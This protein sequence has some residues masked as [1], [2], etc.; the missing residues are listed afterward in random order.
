MSEYEFPADLLE[1][2]REWFA[3]EQ[4]LTELSPREAEL[5]RRFRELSIQISIHPYWETF[6]DGGVVAARMALRQAVR[7]PWSRDGQ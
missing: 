1:A 2:K 4:Q 3:L 6:T 7:P 5:R